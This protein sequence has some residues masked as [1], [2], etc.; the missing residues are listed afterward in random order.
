MVQP[1]RAKTRALRRAE[2]GG[3]A[4]SRENPRVAYPRGLAFVY[5]ARSR[6]RSATAQRACKQSSP[7]ADLT[8]GDGL[9]AGTPPDTPSPSCRNRWSLPS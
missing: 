2:A 3:A 4:R 8:P 9:P 1:A 7:V 5:E 6:Q